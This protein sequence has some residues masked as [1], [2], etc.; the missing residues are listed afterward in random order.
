MNQPMNLTLETLLFRYC[1][2][3]CFSSPNAEEGFLSTSYTDFLMLPWQVEQI[4]L[5]W[6]SEV[7][8]ENNITAEYC[9]KTYK[10]SLSPIAFY[11]FTVF[12]FVTITWCVIRVIPV[13]CMPLPVLSSFAELNFWGK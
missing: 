5:G 8:K 13:I 7:P 11:T 2:D 12:S 6:M 9:R 10:I 1:Q 4:A 3:S